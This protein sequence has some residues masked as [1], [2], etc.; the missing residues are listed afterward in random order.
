MKSQITFIIE[1]D[2]TTDTLE[3]LAAKMSNFAQDEGA[4]VIVWEVKVDVDY[5]GC[6]EC[7]GSNGEHFLSCSIWP[8]NHRMT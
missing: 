3:H 4:S 1:H 8:H 5:N 7:G 2:E 6:S